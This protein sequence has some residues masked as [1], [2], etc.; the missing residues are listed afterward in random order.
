MYFLTPGVFALS[1][2][3]RLRTGFPSRYSSGIIFLKNVQINKL[4]LSFVNSCRGLKNNYEKF[5]KDFQNSAK[6]NPVLIPG[7]AWPVDK[8]T[9]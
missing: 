8:L 6:K 9:S 3:F 7:Q 4:Y 2:L 5:F 1:P